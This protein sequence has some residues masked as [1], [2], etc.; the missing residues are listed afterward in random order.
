MHRRKLILVGML[1]LLLAL[2]LPGFQIVSSQTIRGKEI[3]TGVWE[4]WEVEY[5]SGQ[6]L[7]KLKLEASIQDIDTLLIANQ[8]KIVQELDKLRIGMAE[9]PD[10]LDLFQIIEKIKIHPLIEFAE[11]NLVYYAFLDEP[12]DPY[13]AGTSPATYRYQWALHNIGQSPP[14]GT[15]DADIDAPEA[16]EIEKGNSTVQIIAILDSGIPMQNGILS[17]PDL[18]DPY[19][20]ILGPDYYDDGNGVKDERG[21]GTHVAGIASAETN[22]GTGIAGVS[23]YS[24]IL[25]IQVFGAYGG[26]TAEI[27]KN[28]IIYAVDYGA[29]VINFSG[30]APILYS[31]TGRTIR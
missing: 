2:A 26:T 1:A 22:N 4:G 18:N 25:V 14:G 30:G 11:P 20:I 3:K 9:V 8:A 7:F 23:W 10:S 19:K 12:D 16:W 24:K 29:R 21:H 13:Y 5:I 15:V 17:H 27:V 28:G 6:V 31:R